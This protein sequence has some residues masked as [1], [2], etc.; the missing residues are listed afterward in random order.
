M[1][2]NNNLKKCWIE[3]IQIHKALEK[4]WRRQREMRRFNDI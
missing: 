1:T 2:K 3:I 4:R